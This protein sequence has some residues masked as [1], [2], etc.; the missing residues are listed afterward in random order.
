[1][2]PLIS[3]V[4]PVYNTKEVWLRECFDS[5]IKQ[6]YVDWEWILCDNG[7]NYNTAELLQEYYEY[8]S[9]I[10]LCSLYKNE[11]GY[12]G[13]EEGL[14]YVTGDY[15]ALM[16]SDDTLPF[17][18]L[19]TIAQSLNEYKPD[20]LYTDETLIDTDNKTIGTFIK[21]DYDKILLCFMHY[22]G[23]LTVYR[24]ALIK[25]LGLRHCGGS[26]DYD[27]ALRSSELTTHI[28]HIPG[29]LYNYRIYPESTSAITRESCIAGGLQTLQEHLD[30]E[31][32]FGTIASHD[33]I[34]YKVILGN[35]Q[36][37]EPN[38]LDKY[39]DMLIKVN[40]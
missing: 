17:Q 26:Y 15:V 9:R 29:L 39:S 32:G 40:K 22:W 8:D 4:T 35:G 1:M 23:H 31:Y 27:L 10:T 38:L 34:L 2:K 18:A 11:G 6:S 21:P 33:G 25:R 20:V 13:I 24:T 16:D 36:V 28:F 30:L 5:V 3:L 19:E 7:G 12:K 14:K 37:L